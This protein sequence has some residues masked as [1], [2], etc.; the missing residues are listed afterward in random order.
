MRDFMGNGSKKESRGFFFTVLALAMLSLMLFTVQIWVRVLEQS[1]IRSSERFKGEA[2]R[3]VLTTLS[4]EALSDFSGA[5]AYYATYKLANYTSF[6]GLAE[7]NSSDELNNPKT[8][9][10]EA[11][12][13][14][15][16]LNGTTSLTPALGY[17]SDENASYTFAA[18]QD[19]IQKSANLMGFNTSFSA[20]QGFKIKQ[21]GPWDIQVS[22]KTQMN[23][24][25]LDGT[26]RQTKHVSANSTFSIKGFPDPAIKR[27]YISYHLFDSPDAAPDKQIFTHPSYNQPADLKPL[28]WNGVRGNG[29]FFGPLTERYPEEINATELGKLKQYILLTRYDPRLLASA[30]FYGAVILTEPPVIVTEYD[31]SLDGCLYNVTTETKCINCK[32]TYSSSNPFWSKP[33]VYINT[34]DPALPTLVLSGSEVISLIPVVHREGMVFEDQRFALIDNEHKLHHDQLPG[35]YHRLWDVTKIRDMAICGFYVQETTAPSFFQRMLSSPFLSTRQSTYGIESFVVGTWAGGKDD[36][37]ADHPLYSKLD[38]E[39]FTGSYFPS[40]ICRVKG[41]MGCK[42]TEMCSGGISNNAT[43]DAVGVFR[44]SQYAIG[45]YG[46]KDISCDFPGSTTLSCD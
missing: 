45:R 31:V 7:A 26:M 23:I 32:V 34:T 18:W 30:D 46:L 10:V 41:M 4:D 13:E 16:I 27:S 35:D 2:M 40:Q 43:Q 44:L 19:R 37:I 9:V 38:R 6:F 36:L 8:G 25:D 3:Q 33:S 15:L 12:L 42:S 14:S 5:S 1:D 21:I 24:S 11:T 20:P 17:S 39:F 29:W 28:R 22:F